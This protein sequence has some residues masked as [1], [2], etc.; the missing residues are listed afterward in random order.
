M[1][2][3]RFPLELSSE[4]E[5]CFPP[6]FIGVL[7]LIKYAGG[8]LQFSFTGTDELK[9]EVARTCNILGANPNLA[10]EQPAAEGCAEPAP[11]S[12]NEAPILVGYLWKK[13]QSASRAD[14]SSNVWYR[15]WFVLKRDNCLYYYKNQDVSLLHFCLC[16]PRVVPQFSIPGDSII[17]G[18]RHVESKLVYYCLMD[19]LVL[20]VPYTYREE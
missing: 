6:S 20:L 18:A 10:Q 1:M 12:S 8:K 11:S 3:R 2:A 9:L 7:Q 19:V 16:C 13:S 14:E 5:S 4:G 15:R 17:R